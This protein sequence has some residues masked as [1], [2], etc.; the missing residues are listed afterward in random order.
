[1]MSGV[2]CGESRVHTVVNVTPEEEHKVQIH[3]TFLEYML[4]KYKRRP[5]YN[6]CTLQTV[7]DYCP[8]L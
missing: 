2:V 1:M 8:E 7:A 3:V 5:Y 4:D 6:A